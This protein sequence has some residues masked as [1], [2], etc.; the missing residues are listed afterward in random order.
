MSTNENVFLDLVRKGGT[1]TSGT[2]YCATTWVELP[3]Q[4][5]KFSPPVGTTIDFN[6]EAGTVSAGAPSSKTITS[7]GDLVADS[8]GYEFCTKIKPDEEEITVPGTGGQ[9][10]TT[11]TEY[12]IELSVTVQTADDGAS[13]TKI[14]TDIWR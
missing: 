7:N 9:P 14:A 6:M 5:A 11:Y 2:E 3:G 10:D 1:D 8:D 13:E 12:S 4:T